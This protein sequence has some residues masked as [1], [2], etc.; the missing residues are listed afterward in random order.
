MKYLTTKTLSAL[1][2]K[3]IIA[4]WNAEFVTT[5]RMG[6]VEDLEKYL[7]GVT[8]HCHLFMLDEAGVIKGWFFTFD[9]EG[10]RWFVMIVSSG[11]QGKGYGSALVAKGKEGHSELNGWVVDSLD[12]KI[13]NGI[14]YRPPLDFYRKNGFEILPEIVQETPRLRTI[15][16]RWAEKPEKIDL[17]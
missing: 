4:L 1:Q 17:S 15:K 2:K 3:E 14:T 16:I 11:F 6:G 7:A 12:Y 9:R 10:Q 8:N 5:I 13:Q